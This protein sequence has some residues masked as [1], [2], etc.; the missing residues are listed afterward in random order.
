MGLLTFA[1]I[2]FKIGHRAAHLWGV[3]WR[4]TVRRQPEMTRGHSTGGK[5]R[6]LGPPKIWLG[7]K[8]TSPLAFTTVRQKPPL[9]G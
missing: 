7:Q 1:C 5:A 9:S 6:G 8:G 4:A 3:Y 2:I